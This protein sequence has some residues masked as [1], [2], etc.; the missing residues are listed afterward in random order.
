VHD[1]NA[2]L[3]IEAARTLLVREI[4]HVFDQYINYRHIEMLVDTMTCRGDLIPITR[5]G[6]QKL[7]VSPLTR[8]TFEEM[9]MQFINAA[10]FAEYD[11][12]TGVS[13]NIM[14][15]QLFPGGT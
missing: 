5:S 12:C 4:A 15:G 3:G 9:D 14:F 6:M 11:G 7:N 10:A 1:V 13:P 2:V 8:A